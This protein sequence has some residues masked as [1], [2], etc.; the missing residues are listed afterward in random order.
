MH[1]RSAGFPLTDTQAPRSLGSREEVLAPAPIAWVICRLAG[2]NAGVSDS[3]EPRC[4]FL[5]SCISR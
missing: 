1:T 2:E 4:F 3:N 5:K